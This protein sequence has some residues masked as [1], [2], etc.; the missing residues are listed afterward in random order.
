MMRATQDAA[1]R[2]HAVTGN[3]D[4]II[5]TVLADAGYN[6]DA[7]LNAEGRTGYR[8]GQRTGPGPPPPRNRPTGHHHRAHPHA[9]STPPTP[10]PKAE[11][12]TNVAER[13]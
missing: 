1:D 12:S 7:N 8:P 6:S 2:L 5:G 3:A 4:H 13:Q 9:K 11:T 10:P